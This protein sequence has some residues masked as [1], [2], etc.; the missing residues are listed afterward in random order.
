MYIL[1]IKIT[2][3]LDDEAPDNIQIM[4]LTCNVK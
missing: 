3:F 4:P 2:S 1:N